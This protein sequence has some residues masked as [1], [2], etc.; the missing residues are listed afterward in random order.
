MQPHYNLQVVDIVGCGSTIG[1]LLRCARSESKTFRFDVDVIGDTLLLV[2]KESSP[3]ELITNLQG[4]GHAFP[5]AYT[6]W[7]SEVRNS[8]CHQ[9]II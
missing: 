2:R 9:H 4:Y 5:E 8:C 3:K 7:D 1:N 6:R